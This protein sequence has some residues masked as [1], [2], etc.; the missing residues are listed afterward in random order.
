MKILVVGGSGVLGGELVRQLRAAGHEILATATTVESAAKIPSEASLR[1]LLDLRSDESIEVLANY[2][3]DSL[4]GLDGIINASGVVTFGG[5]SSLPTLD[6]VFKINALG[7]INFFQQML[8]LLR[9]SAT[10]EKKPFVAA[11]S[12]VV[13]ELPMP[14]M[15]VYSASKSALSSYLRAMAKQERKNGVRF[16]DLRPGHT[17]T[18]LATRPVEGQAPPMPTGMTA[19]SVVSKIV[20]A[21]EGD[22]AELAASAFN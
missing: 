7:P 12:G 1:L 11:I 13:A 10:P 9:R 14:G 20:A 15:A 19:Q 2:L 6:K 5:L 18:G 16:I 3:N 21:I 22:Q 8:P 4:E 17:E